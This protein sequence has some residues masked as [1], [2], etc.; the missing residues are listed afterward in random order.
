MNT[1]QKLGFGIFIVG[2][3]I[4]CS[5]VFIG[6]YQL[7]TEQFEEVINSKGIKSE[8][9]I[10]AIN[11]QVVGKEFSGP[12]TLSTTIIKSIEDANIV[13]RKKRE[14]IKVIWAKPHSFSYEIAKIAGTGV[15]KKTKVYFGFLL[16]GWESLGRYSTYFQMQL[17]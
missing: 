2:L 13:H 16:L 5:L 6:K 4:F 8:L 10:N 3:A 12:F 1:L 14:W 17:H 15:I 11:T 7:S 9:F